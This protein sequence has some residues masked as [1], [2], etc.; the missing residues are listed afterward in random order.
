MADLELGDAL[1]DAPPQ[2]ES[3]IKRDFISS[4]EAEP[5]DDVIGEKCDKTDYIPLLDDDE[6]K[7]S[8][9][10]HSDGD[11]PSRLE[12][13]E[14]HTG[15]VGES[16][17]LGSTHDENVLA[18]HPPPPQVQICPAFAAQLPESSEAAYDEGWL[19][20]SYSKSGDTDTPSADT[21]EKTTGETP[22]DESAKLP[23]RITQNDPNSHIWEPT[24]EE[25]IA[26]G[27]HNTP[28]HEGNPLTPEEESQFDE[29]PNA[30]SQLLPGLESAYLEKHYPEDLPKSDLYHEDVSSTSIESPDPNTENDVH[31]SPDNPTAAEDS[32]DEAASILLSGDSDQPKD[33]DAE[34]VTPECQTSTEP[35]LS[36]AAQISAEPPV[37]PVELIQG[38]SPV[39]PV[40][41]FPAEIQV[42]P[43]TSLGESVQEEVS[44]VSPAAVDQE[45]KAPASPAELFQEAEAPAS[46]VALIQQAEVPAS[47]VALVQEAE[48][49]AS[50][51]ALVQEAE[52]PASPVALVQE[53]E[54]PA[55][56]VALVQEAE[57]PA[58]P[59]ALVQEAEVPASPVALVQE[60]E[61][62]AS[63]VAL[64][65]QA[66][67]PASP[68]ALIQQAEVPASPVALIQQA[69]VPASPV[70]LIQQA[71]VPASPVALIQQAEVPASPVVVQEAEAPA[72]PVALVQEA[73]APASPVA[74]VQENEV[75]ASPVALVLEA[76][77]PAS[78]VVVQDS[79]AP[80]SPA[81]LTQ[82]VE[83]PVSP[84]SPVSQIPGEAF[85]PLVTEIKPPPEVPPAQL[86]TPLGRDALHPGDQ[87]KSE[88]AAAPEEAKAGSDITAPPTKELPAS[89]EKKVKT[90]AA[91][92]TPSKATAT[93]KGRSLAAPSPKK[94]LSSTPTQ[95]KKVS[96]PALATVNNATPKR[97]LGGAAKTATPKDTKETK[98]KGLDLKSPVKSPD[99]KPLTSATSPRP[100]LRT[101]P[102]ASKLGTSTAAHTTGTSAPKPNVPPKRPIS[103]K[104]DVKAAD[105]KKTNPTRSPT[106]LSR[107][108]SVPA[109]LTKSNG[110]A[111]TVPAT[112][113]PK[114]SK[115]AASKTLTGPSA[116]ADAKKLPA[117]RPAPL[118][119][120][121]TAPASKPT[122]ALA[123]SKPTAA[124]KQPRPA[125]APDL[126]NVRSKIGSTDN[127]KH[128]PGGG[129]AKVEKKPVPVSTARKPVPAPAAT[130]TAGTKP[131]DPKETAQKQSNGKVQIV[132]KK[133]NYGHVQSKCGSKDNIKHVPGG[134]NVTNAAKPSVGSS[135]PPAST[136]HKS[137]GANVQILSKKVDVSKVS[138]KCGSKP[139]VKA[140]PGGAD[141]KPDK[142]V[143]KTETTKPE[144]QESI[145]ENGGEQI[146]PPQNGDQAPPTDNTAADTRENGVEET[147]PVDGS[148]QRE[149]QSFNSLIPET[150]I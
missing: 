17:P 75:P 95:L 102:S 105:A 38:S 23:F 71:E 47:P 64:V 137:G 12:N 48:V 99:K 94:P 80:A 125:T 19:T 101:T 123:S 89:P 136:N 150:S 74:L 31:E 3:E 15:D 122:S 13:G 131:A 11:P 118:N 141:A 109:D 93:P 148:D 30:E 108:K 37:S 82:A 87:G 79:G 92:A 56:P 35:P 42:E 1:T 97:P 107:P 128:Q 104:N 113:R 18:D 116:S 52:V 70:A 46:P 24:A 27:S 40:E 58:S 14:D 73:E 145:K 135:R 7:G 149:T 81:T 126:K 88:M 28:E 6:A 72:S 55:S 29:A 36:P 65:Q 2:I 85:T 91:A 49:P 8:V 139:N 119:K 41:P 132:S 110:T 127:L 66:E 115:P 68:V 98:A 77:A 120:S 51:V 121:G 60:A 90:P 69:E 106:E 54:V 57:V 50:P 143:K 76:E 43:L 84:A 67:V 10:K 45:T 26:L 96:S 4:L 134:G 114:T 33:I 78:P 142:I 21:S 25:Q 103:L 44:P 53:A 144:P 16:D 117:T 111:P 138:S 59:V 83:T 61:V 39:S 133:L 147:P 140:K 112:S 9:T 86:E 32:R 129:K 100:A 34:Q 130:K 63:P 62:P 22:S 20:D 146:A 5:Y 124:P